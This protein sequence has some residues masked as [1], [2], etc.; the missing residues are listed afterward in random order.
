MKRA[1]LFLAALGLAL[2]GRAQADTSGTRHVSLTL[3]LS[4][5]TTLF[6]NGNDMS[7]YYSKYGFALHL[8]L[9]VHYRHSPRWTFSAGLQYDFQWSPLYHRVE[10][11]ES[12]EGIDFPSGPVVGDQ[13][14]YAFH[15][16]LGFPLQATWYPFRSYGRRLYLNFDIHPAYAI[17]RLIYINEEVLSRTS[18][19][20]WNDGTGGS[21]MYPWKLEVGLTLGTSA[22]GL[23]HGLRL[24]VNLLPTYR[25][26]VSG[27]D[28]YIAGLQFF[29]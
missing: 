16:Y 20:L 2:G 6:A 11:V 23:L 24:F 9:T 28:I 13:R 26:V 22:V 12:G 29:L 17:N 18:S 3:G 7:P 4:A 10:V 5:S 19:T 21:C 8:P 25:D 27:E 14:A 1:I 15:G